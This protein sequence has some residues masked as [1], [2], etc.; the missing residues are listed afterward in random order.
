LT[1]EVERQAEWTQFRAVDTELLVAAELFGGLSLEIINP[2]LQ[3]G[4]A[5]VNV[6]DADCLGE[7]FGGCSAKGGRRNENDNSG[8][9]RAKLEGPES[10]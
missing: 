9:S 1:A 3:S 6:F 8:K 7:L 2:F 5:K 4:S 10:H